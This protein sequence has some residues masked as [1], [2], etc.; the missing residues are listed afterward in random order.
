MFVPKIVHGSQNPK[1]VTCVVA[2]QPISVSM[3]WYYM[4]QIFISLLEWG[5]WYKGTWKS[6][7]VVVVAVVVHPNEEDWYIYSTVYF[8]T[9]INSTSFCTIDN[10]FVDKRSSYTIKPYINGLSDH[11]AQLLTLNDWAQPIS[12][13]KPVYIRNINKHTTAEFQSL[14]SW[15]QWQDVFGVSNVYIMINN[16][17]NT[18]FRCYYT[19]FLKINISKFYQSHNEWITK[20]IKVSC[21]RKKELFVLC[22][23]NNN[24]NLKRYYKKYC[25]ILTRVICSAKKLHYNNIILRSKKR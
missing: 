14:L 20:G 19:S 5:L 10:I 9:R 6:F 21:K 11:Y 23:I 8:P 24:H 15:E 7:R 12:I 17:L 4:T 25:L 2:A 3:S 18:Y 13:T 1:S 22:K 16:F